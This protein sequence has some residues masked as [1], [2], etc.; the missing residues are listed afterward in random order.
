MDYIAIKSEETTERGSNHYRNK[1]KKRKQ[2]AKRFLHNAKGFGRIGIFGRGAEVDQEQYNYLVNILEAMTKQ[3]DTEERQLMANNVLGQLEGKEIRI[4]S[5]QLGSRVFEN[6]LPFTDEENFAKLMDTFAENFRAVCCDKFASHVLQRM[7]YVALLRAVAPLQTEDDDAEHGSTEQEGSKKPRQTKGGDGVDRAGQSIWPFSE[8]TLKEP[9]SDAHRQ[10]C[11]KFVQRLAMFLINNLEEFVWDNTA[12]YIVRQCILNLSG[13]G[14]MKMFD[15]RGTKGTPMATAE[16]KRLIVPEEWQKLLTEINIRLMAWPQFADLP[17]NELASVI[18]QTLL[19]ALS[20]LEERFLVSQLCSKLHNE[21]FLTENN[22]A[23]K[24]E[25]DASEYA[26]EKSFAEEDESKLPKVFQQEASIRLLESCI[27]VAPSNFFKENLFEGL[28]RG[29]LKDLA[30]SK[31]HNFAVQ[32]LIEHTDDKDLIEIVL[33]EL[34]NSMEDILRVGHTGVVLA[35][36]KACARL[37]CQQGKY[38]KLLLDALHSGE[39]ASEKMITAVLYLLPAD[40]KVENTPSINLHGSLILQ[41]ILEFNKPIKFVNALLEMPNDRLANILSDPRGSFVANAYTGSRFVGEKSREKM[42]R[43]L[44]GQYSRLM[45][46]PHGS[47]VVEIMYNA[48]NP[49]QRENIVRELADNCEQ[50]NSKPWGMV[51]NKRLLVDTY[52]RDP[53][54]WKVAIKSDA[55]VEKLF[56]KLV[57]GKKRKLNKEGKE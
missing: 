48:G 44:E 45:L 37:A 33:L 20:T 34:E 23:K 30:L 24:E 6:L 13:I 40:I 25:D 19:R 21:A 12:N 10:M 27:S 18:L 56:D 7:L 29:R 14:E 4:S 9:Y 17:Y 1:M 2:F 39:V 47:H 28:F 35:L 49:A 16:V 5:N 57:G 31:M 3:K 51:I 53:A 38:V 42:V 22:C 26:E 8:Y 55:K 41:A 36:A 52:K 50:L 11:G 46:T 43:H 32:K 15:N 54:R